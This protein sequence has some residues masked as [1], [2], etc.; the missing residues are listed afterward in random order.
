MINVGYNGFLEDVH[1]KEFIAIL[2]TKPNLSFKHR[3]I[4]ERYLDGIL[5]ICRVCL[6][7]LLY[8]YLVQCTWRGAGF[9]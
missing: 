7:T 3:G 9:H 8:L 5:Q 6:F 2:A 1:F 4:P